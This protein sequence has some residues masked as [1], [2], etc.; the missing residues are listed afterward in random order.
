MWNFLHD[1]NKYI[2]YVAAP[3]TQDE[4]DPEQMADW[5]RLGTALDN[6]T[7]TLYAS[8]PR[9]A[10][11]CAEWG[12]EE[13]KA[14][15]TVKLNYIKTQTDLRKGQCLALIIVGESPDKIMRRAYLPQAVCNDLNLWDED[16]PEHEAVAMITFHA[17][18]DKV[19]YL[20]AAI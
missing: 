18:H 20:S 12:H 2:V 10:G 19:E 1:F 17:D 16:G 8:H 5:R 13:P 9:H 11:T 4:M 15:L 14:R 7:A 3:D 6:Q